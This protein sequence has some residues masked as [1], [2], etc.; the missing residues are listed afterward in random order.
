M[1]PSYFTEVRRHPSLISYWRHNDAVSSRVLIDYA[2]RFNLTG[3]YSSRSVGP[4]LILNDQMASSSKLGAS[5]TASVPDASELEIVG[6]LSIEAWIVPFVGSETVNIIGK[7]DNTASFAGPYSLRLVAGVLNFS[8]GNGSSQVSLTAG[9][10]SVSSPSHVVVTSFRG[11]M[12]TF[13]NGNQIG[14]RTVGSQT[15]ADV[16]Q[17]VTI[18][19]TSAHAGIDLVSEVAIYNDA[20]SA[21]QVARHYAL[22]QQTLPDPAHY[23]LVDSPQIV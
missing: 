21:L 11:V 22:G 20:L 1:A 5:G 4:A 7:L 2:S 23:A 18:G 3:I 8:I 19:A 17:P 6:P 15:I 13:L 16:A 10:P 12:T 14:M 9:V